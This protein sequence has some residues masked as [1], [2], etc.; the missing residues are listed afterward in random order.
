MELLTYSTILLTQGKVAI[1]DA[2]DY[3]W[4]SQWKWCATKDK[5]DLYYAMR[6]IKR[7]AGR[8]TTVSMHREILRLNPGEIGIDHIDSNGLNNRKANLRLATPSQN[9]ANG[10][11]RKGRSQYKGVSWHKLAQKWRSRT[12][13]NYKSY[14]LGYFVDEIEAACAYDAKAKELFGEY[15]KLNFPRGR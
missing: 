7:A 9:N 2:E 8:R 4:L 3:E 12:K 6:T 15:A 1:I 5:A 11:S 10:R 13:L 14:H